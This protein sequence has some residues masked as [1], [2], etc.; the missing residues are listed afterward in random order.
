MFLYL[1][2]HPENDPRIASNNFKG[3]IPRKTNVEKDLSSRGP[4]KWSLIRSVRPRRDRNRE[5][6]VV[7]FKIDKT[8]LVDAFVK[9][10][11]SDGQPFGIVSESGMK[12]LVDPLL[13]ALNVSLDEDILRQEVIERARRIRE[14]ILDEVFERMVS[15][16][17][18]VVCQQS[19]PFI[20]ISI[21]YVK[22]GKKRFRIL[23]VKEISAVYNIQEL[24]RI[25]WHHLT[26][27]GITKEQLYTVT[28]NNDSNPLK[29]RREMNSRGENEQDSDTDNDNQ[30]ENN[31]DKETAI[32]ISA[33]LRDVFIAE[34]EENDSLLS[35]NIDCL[36]SKIQ[37][38]AQ[39]AITT[40]PDSKKLVE[41]ARSVANKLRSKSVMALLKSKGT[42]PV[43]IDC[44]SRWKSTFSMVKRLQNNELRQVINEMGVLSS[45]LN[46]PQ[47]EWDKMEKFIEAFKPLVALSV[48]VEELQLTVGDF[49]KDWLKCKMETQKLDSEFAR[50]IAGHMI[51]FEEKMIKNRAFLTA[52][53]L[54]PRI[55]VTLSE[56]QTKK[57]R[58]HLENTWRRVCSVCR[59][60]TE[61]NALDEVEIDPGN[62]SLE[63]DLEIFLRSKDRN[64]IQAML[65][66]SFLSSQF[67]SYEE[68]PREKTSTNVIHFW[69]SS[70][71]ATP[72]LCQLAMIALACP[73]NETG[74][75]R[76]W[77]GVRLMLNPSFVK[78][79]EDIIDDVI[80]VNT[81]QLIN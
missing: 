80:L 69:E 40:Q 31:D 2:G 43:I 18:D 63:D 21:H 60:Q 3:T 26:D 28:I 53:Y 9:M 22:R 14:G 23:G 11:I 44:R 46:I 20:G 7:T 64:N 61:A 59:L 52:V 65:N 17:V 37:S 45:D 71:Q 50:N 67:K 76:I 54:D 1:Q 29:A 32:A 62:S 39:S 55:R 12:M 27:Y 41:K 47:A 36:T 25:I 70:G 57:A 75:E 38:M 56:D 33:S 5:Q 72:E 48:C 19:R 34:K 15:L 49:Y 81:N 35:T 42:K 68:R 73:V 24:K 10:I 58:Q 6:S 66:V 51:K 13:E 78:L 4:S 74:L 79:P 16:K 8:V 77:S 30:A